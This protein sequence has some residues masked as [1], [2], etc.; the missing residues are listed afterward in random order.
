MK[1]LDSTGRFCFCYTFPRPINFH[2]DESV[3]AVLI[4]VLKRE[5]GVTFRDH[6]VLCSS[7]FPLTQMFVLDQRSSGAGKSVLCQRTIV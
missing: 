6:P 4:V 7:D 1:V 3:G 2:D 5:G